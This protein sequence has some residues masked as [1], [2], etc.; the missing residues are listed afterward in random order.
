[1]KVICSYALIVTED[2]GLLIKNPSIIKAEDDIVFMNGDSIKIG[3]VK[4]FPGSGTCVVINDGT[5]VNMIDIVGI[6][7]K[8]LPIYQIEALINND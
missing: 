6:L 7:V 5:Y 4:S 3:T 8:D 2:K 1:M